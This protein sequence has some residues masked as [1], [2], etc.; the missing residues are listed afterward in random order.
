MYLMPNS[1]IPVKTVTAPIRARTMPKQ[2]GIKG[3]GDSFIKEYS[4]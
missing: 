2:D 4:I 3:I 1:K